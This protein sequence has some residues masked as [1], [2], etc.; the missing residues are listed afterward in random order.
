MS[1]NVSNKNN[2]PV[3]VH[4]AEALIL[5]FEWKFNGTFA[6][7]REDVILELAPQ[8]TRLSRS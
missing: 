1:S 5:L 8:L 2:K 6:A 4:V 3:R 7:V